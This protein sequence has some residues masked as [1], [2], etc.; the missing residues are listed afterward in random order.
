[1]THI[2]DETQHHTFM[3]SY[4]WKNSVDEKGLF[5]LRFLLLQFFVL[6]LWSLS[7][8]VKTIPIKDM[9]PDREGREQRGLYSK[10]GP[11][12]FHPLLPLAPR[13]II[14]PKALRCSKNGKA[15]MVKASSLKGPKHEI[16]GFGFFT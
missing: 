11:R 7:V 9:R 12:S 8:R 1:M 13:D 15:S 2:E 5:L 10:R 3:F 6:V 16:F 14:A 4:D